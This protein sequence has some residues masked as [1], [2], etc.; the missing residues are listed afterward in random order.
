MKRKADSSLLS[1]VPWRGLLSPRDALWRWD[2]IARRFEV[3]PALA[4]RLGYGPT[5]LNDPA[6]FERVIHPDDLPLLHRG[7]NALFDGEMDHCDW[8]E[9]RLVGRDGAEH[10]FVMRAMLV[11]DDAGRPVRMDGV[12]IDI[13]EQRA[14]QAQSEQL[15][16]R[17]Q[18]LIDLLPHMVYVRDEHGRF[19]L[20]NLAMAEM[21]GCTVR[22]LV[23][24][25]LMELHRD[26]GQ[27]QYMLEGDR[28]I[29]AG[30][31]KEMDGEEPFMHADGSP[32][33]LRTAR[34]SYRHAGR[35]AVLGISENVTT[36][37]R[38]ESRLRNAEE[39]FRLLAE[40]VPGVIYLCHNDAR[41]TMLYINDAVEGLTGYTREQFMADEVSFVELFHPDDAS[42]I[43]PTVN[44]ALARRESY[45]L[46]YRIRHRD[47]AWRWI[48]E[49]GVGVFHDDELVY[50]EGFLQ[51]VTDRHEAEVALRNMRDALEQR[52]TERTA[53]LVKANQK[54]SEEVRER[55]DAELA[56]RREQARFRSLLATIPDVVM[57]LDGDGRYREVFTSSPELLV[58]PR[59]QLIGHTIHELLDGETAGAVQAVIDRVLRDRVPAT[60]EYELMIR[61][62]R[63]MY[64]ARVVPYSGEGVPAVLWVA[65][66]VTE[67]RVAEQELR[68]SRE[69]YASAEHIAHLGHFE[70]DFERDTVSWSDETFRIFGLDPAT[71][72]PGFDSFMTIVHPDDREHIREMVRRAVDQGEA[73]DSEYRIIRADG[74]VRVI[75]CTGEAR[76]ND[77]GQRTVVTGAVHDI[78]EQKAAEH[79]LRESEERFRL[80][81]K[82]NPMPIYTW[83]RGDE[84]FVLYDL[85]DAA[86]AAMQGAAAGANGR[87]AAEHFGRMPQVLDE[88]DRA[89]QTQA[90]SA[91]E[92]TYEDEQG[93]QRTLALRFV[94][95]PPD[96]VMLHA[97][98]ITDRQRAAEAL[99]TG[100]AEEEAY[101]KQL[102]SLNRVTN[103][104]SLSTST[105]A[106]CRAAV[107]AAVTELDVDRAS[108]WFYDRDDGRIV[109]TCGTDESGW[110][111]DERQS[112]LAPAPSSM[113]GRVLAGERPVLHGSATLL[114]DQGQAV[115]EGEQVVAALTDGHTVVGALAVD[116]LL[117]GRPFT[118]RQV[119]MLRLYATT[120]GHLCAR[121]R[122]MEAVRESDER[123]QAIIDNSTAVIYVKDIAGRYILVNRHFE[124]LFDVTS[125]ALCGRDDFDLFPRDLAE[126]FRANDMRVVDEGSPIEFEEVAP[127]ADGAHTYISMKFPLRDAQ[128]Q[129]T[130]ICGISTDITDRKRAE[131]QL[132]ESEARY[133]LLA[134]NTTDMISRET[135]TGRYLYVSPAC[136]ALL[137]YDPD[138]LHGRDS[139][140]FVH[141]EDIEDVRAKRAM[142]E[143]QDRAVISCRMYRKDGRYV[144]IEA[145][146]RALRDTA[147][148]Q[149]REVVTVTRDISE[150]KRAEEAMRRRERLVA[151]GTMA[152]GIAHE[153]NNPLGAILF[154]AHVA[155]SSAGDPDKRQLHDD[156]LDQ[157]VN[158]AKRCA[159][160]VKGVLQFARHGDSMKAPGSIGEI[161]RRAVDLTR[162]D[163][164]ERRLNVKVVAPSS[165]PPVWINST[166]IEQVL[167]NSLLNASQA[168][169]NQV[170]VT[171][172][173]DG[174]RQ[175]VIVAVRDDGQGMTEQ[176]VR[177]AF[178]P[179]YTGRTNIGTGL[180]LS[181]SHNIIAAHGGD[182]RIESEP[183]QGATLT[184]S[185]PVA[186][187]T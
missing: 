172:R 73:F 138:D 57:V 22:E 11:R 18:Q 58:R 145:T 126:A 87:P 39:Q 121:L 141:V 29:L 104:L 115:G 173:H 60:T 70:R 92:V 12:H 184:F 160:I 8:P 10:W 72:D 130:A 28:Q 25:S 71:F 41:Y 117:H 61:G 5:E 152:A 162:F 111:R 106:L 86:K 84:G 35:P 143:A 51:D 102:M 15:G 131:Q 186:P 153:I 31:V 155:R 149:V 21:F 9:H 20:A 110:V 171:A 119:E 113:M 90:T 133:R 129:V 170:R 37:H 17:F 107:Q 169:A 63:K 85:N 187:P 1:D 26:V 96:L 135:L 55:E 159:K 127:H 147:T 32:A 125:E 154:S 156:T 150:R 164:A 81:F 181:I 151:V 144:W 2:I 165:L 132:R 180:G 94:P 66:D 177:R 24:R 62:Q 179:F 19:V 166:E 182:I 38:N 79:A 33:T 89:I 161:I 98:D 157:I 59:G 80:H 183:G 174:D 48:E 88:L 146:S 120:V 112:R 100:R 47:G 4:R 40:N 101:R 185:L 44:A 116:N 6:A 77:A 49:V 167:V 178:D 168:G 148:D 52:V 78:T 34:V 50:L 140:D 68:R 114:N 83:R 27:A 128:G 36:R 14:V 122:A 176:Q 105:D 158:D 136:R 16:Q 74:A 43:T 23:G 42:E 82:N 30:R 69:L 46:R 13:G 54:L 108:I 118:D 67:Q 124:Q 76:L 95:V 56:V 91:R 53:E 3:E 45:H 99:A 93:E 109:G 137:G 7:V 139:F 65:R 175:R 103:E 142:L 64:S 97:E 134:D 75:H 123:I 163:A